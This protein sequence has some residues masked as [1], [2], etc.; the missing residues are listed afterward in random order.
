VLEEEGWHRERAANRLGLP[1]RT[2]Y[3]KIRAY[4]LLPP[5]GDTGH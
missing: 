5:D 3:R 1:V 4:D 2:L